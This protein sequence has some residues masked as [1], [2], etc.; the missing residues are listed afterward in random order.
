MDVKFKKLL[1]KGYTLI[2][3]DNEGKIWTWGYNSANGECGT[4]TTENVL[5]PTC[6]STESGLRLN[7]NDQFANNMNYFYIMKGNGEAW[8]WGNGITTP[9]KLNDLEELNGSKIVEIAINTSSNKIDVLTEYG[10]LFRI[11]NTL[12]VEAPNGTRV[13]ERTTGPWPFEFK[14]V[15][16]NKY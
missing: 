16:N 12:E 3:V 14:V 2:A 15:H 8:V 9:T 4:G 13:L 1:N 10:E 6:I 7:D 11:S 5:E